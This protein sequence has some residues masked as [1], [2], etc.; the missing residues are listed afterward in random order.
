MYEK[1]R[2]AILGCFF[3]ALL[4]IALIII[5]YQDVPPPVFE[6]PSGLYEEGT[7]IVLE[8]P[9]GGKI[10]YTLDGTIPDR[11]SFVYD[12]PIILYDYSVNENIYSA[13]D[14][15]AFKNALF[16]YTWIPQKNIS[17][18]MVIN[19]V[20]YGKFGSRSENVR[21]TY[22]CK[23]EYNGIP[24]LSLSVDP[25]DLFGYENGIYVKGKIFD[26]YCEETNQTP[27]EVERNNKWGADSNM[28][29]IDSTTVR[30]AFIEFFYNGINMYSSDVNIKI[31]GGATRYFEQKSFNVYFN[32]TLN[33]ALFTDNISDVSGEEIQE[34]D[35]FIIRN[36]GNN[37]RRY[38]FMDPVIQELV[39]DREISVQSSTPCIVYLNGEY[40]GLYDLKEKYDA[41]Y[42]KSHYNI[43]E[44]DMILVKYQPT[45]DK[46]GR[47][48]TIGTR[49]SI[50][51]WKDF[52]NF[53]KSAD[54]SKESDYSRLCE[55]LDINSFIDNFALHVYTENIDFPLNNC[56]Y[57][58]TLTVN[59]ELYHDGKWRMILYD[60]DTDLRFPNYYNSIEIFKNNSL[61]FEKLLENDEFVE[62]FLLRLC[63][64]SNV[65]FDKEK[66]T[67]VVEEYKELCQ[68]YISEYYDRYGFDNGQVEYTESDKADY[69]D[70]SCNSIISFFE[71]QKQYMHNYLISE[72][73]ATGEIRTIELFGEELNGLMQINS[74]YIRLDETGWEGQY[75]SN[76]PITLTYQSDDENALVY[77]YDEYD[78]LLAVGQTYQTYLDQDKKIVCRLIKY[79]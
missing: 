23:K 3:I 76:L 5:K 39:K 49:E 67:K 74:S 34:Y 6:L 25:D 71:N 62:L 46:T 2:N 45:K 66:V 42:F 18:A 1:K 61:L 21:R 38:I 43:D 11:N 56:G 57:W 63:D 40:W 51:E 65:D 41:Q 60:L 10:Y 13:R 79:E 16:D 44:N 59:D 15:V 4:I 68:P 27:D 31:H 36:W 78:N 73:L 14:D 50:Q 58:K 30:K 35:S 32:K 22:F 26:K 52:E 28:S 19:A 72:G 8:C 24:V 9:E 17:K 33:Y 48:V 55:M 7:E 37:Y 20:V 70:F 75:F 54:F 77:W 53:V 12:G 64:M 29:Q 69:Y 47:E